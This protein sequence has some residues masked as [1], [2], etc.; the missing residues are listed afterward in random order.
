MNETQGSTGGNDNGMVRDF[1][2]LITR[3]RKEIEGVNR[4]Q[5][6][7]EWLIEDQESARKELMPFGF[8]DQGARRSHIVLADRTAVELGPPSLA[9]LDI[10]M[11][12]SNARLVNDGRITLIGDDLPDLV[13]NKAGILQAVFL[14]L[15]PEVSLNRLTL[16]N[17]RYLFNQIPGYMVRSVPGRLW[18]RIDHALMEKGFSFYHLGCALYAVFRSQ[19]EGLLSCEVAFAAGEN[20]LINR[21]ER[22]SRQTQVLSRENRKLQVDPDGIYS[23]TYLDCESCDE[24][25]YCDQ[26]RDLIKHRKKRK[27]Q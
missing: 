21:F 2:L 17:K 18:I 6:R 14:S 9:S 20:D 4:E 26:I 7:K 25:P 27:L 10:L 24:K 8:H 16:E 11:T 19:G 23:C 1:A 15:A 22:I 5:N 12:T 3:F 13:R